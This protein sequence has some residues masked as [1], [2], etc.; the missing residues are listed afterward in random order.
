MDGSPVFPRNPEDLRRLADGDREAFDAFFECWFPRVL[1]W[2]H[3]RLSSNADARALA[4]ASLRRA[5]L[6]LDERNEAMSFARFML[7]VLCLELD[8]RRP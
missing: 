8:A 7:A 5:L 6:H 1:G 2:C 4:E 3:K